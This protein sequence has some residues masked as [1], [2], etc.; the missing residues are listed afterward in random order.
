MD[1]W[2]QL[3][4]ID[5]ALLDVPIHVIGVGG[6]GSP[7]VFALTKMGCQNITVYDDDFIEFHNLPN[8]MFGGKDLGKLK[9]QSLKEI[10]MDF[11]DVELHT[12]EEKFNTRDVSGIVISGVDSMESRADI[13]KLLK[14][15]TRVPLYIDARMGGEICRIYSVN[16]LSPSSIE[17]YESTLYG[18]AAELPCTAR[19]VIYNVF[20]IASL[21]SNQ[22]KKH[23]KGED[24]YPE[25]IFDLA[26]MLLL[27]N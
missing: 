9:T 24:F 18:D 5:P 10:C 13:W 19:A 12:K 22:V 6:I 27:T 14:Y 1:F 20:M 4:I 23:V 21:I 3:N 15:N 8:Q 17:F 7:T 11:N 25:I 26:T 2:R 16:P